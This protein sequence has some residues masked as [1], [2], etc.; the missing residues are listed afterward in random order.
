MYDY[1]YEISFQTV[2][3]IEDVEETITKLKKSID[4]KE[5][6][7]ALVHTRLLN[8]T[9]REGVELC[10]DELEIKLYDEV[11]ELEKN[12]KNLNEMLADS[13]ACLRHLKQTTIRIDIQL[14]VKENSLHI[15]NEL[16]AEQRK[17]INYRAF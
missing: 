13:T 6:C 14:D 3:K 9:R 16:C 8:R 2:K 17:L 10:R 4:D 7:I 15:D 1:Y 11:V 12:V 5:A